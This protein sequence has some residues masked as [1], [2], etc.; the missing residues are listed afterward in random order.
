MALCGLSAQAQED[1]PRDAPKMSPAE[2]AQKLRLAEV[3]EENRDAQNAA[4]VYGELFTL[5][6]SD[7]NVFEGYTR[8]LVVLKKYDEAEKIVD[9]RLKQVGEGSGQSLDILL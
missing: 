7:Q 4:R 6:P 8:A 2:Y 1:E 5:N 9:R 3:Y